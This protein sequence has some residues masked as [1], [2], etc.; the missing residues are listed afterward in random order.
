MTSPSVLP[1]RL[2]ADPMPM[3]AEWFA[4]ARDHAGLR[5][6]DAMVLATATPDGR[7]SARVVLL[8]RLEV[9][10]GYVVF[11][12]NYDSRK[13]GELDSNPRAAATLHWDGLGR[14]VRLEGPVL[15]ATAAESDEYFASRPLDSRIGA[16]A[17]LQSQPLD[18]RTTL[19]GRVATQAARHGTSVPRPPHWGGY[20][21]WP[22]TVELWNEGAFRVHDR[23]RW[24]RT[25]VP[26]GDADCT[27]GPWT[28]TRL[29]P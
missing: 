8:K 29:Y 17:S 25:V 22:D 26:S 20:R 15:R 18:S 3:F 9:D 7:P 19:L 27:T 5:Y 11:Y 12:T 28:A 24:T 10:P 14:Q 1:G 13:G 21:L 6:P 4:H 2:P 23:A 16:W